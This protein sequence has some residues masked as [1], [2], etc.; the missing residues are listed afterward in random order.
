MS[1]VRFTVATRLAL[2]LHAAPP[3]AEP[4]PGASRVRLPG[5]RSRHLTVGASPASGRGERPVG[6]G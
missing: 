2:A 3:G 5:S 6:N 4:S 1:S